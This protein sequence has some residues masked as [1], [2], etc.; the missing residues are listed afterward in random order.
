MKRLALTILLLSG[1]TLR[2]LAASVG[3]TFD[4]E[5]FEIVGKIF[6]N[7]GNVYA[8]TS[9]YNYGPVWFLIL[10]LFQSVASLF[11]NSFLVFR[12]LI[13]LLLTFTDL[14][15]WRLFYNRW[16]L[17]PAF[18]YFLNPISI[19]TTGYYSQFDG[20]AF[21]L[22][23]LSISYLEKSD[24]LHGIRKHTLFG[25]FVMGLSLSTKHFLFF[26]PLWFIFRLKKAGKGILLYSLPYVVFLIS[27]LPF[28]SKGWQGILTNVF[29]YSSLN[30]APFWNVLIPDFL[31]REISPGILFYGAVIVGAWL[32]RKKNLWESFAYYG[33]ILVLFSQAIAEQY[34]IYTLSFISLYFN[35]FFLIFIII[36]TLLMFLMALGGEYTIRPIGFF[37]YRGS[38]GFTWQIVF[39]AL[40]FLY[41][42][43]KKVVKI[44]TS[45]HVIG[46][47]LGVNALFALFINIPSYF[48]DKWVSKIQHAIDE[49]DYEKA[50]DLYG[51]TQA[52]P[53]FAGSRYWWKLTDVRTFIEYFR[54]YR[55]AFSQYESNKIVSNWPETINKLKHIP[56]SFQ[57]RLEVEKIIGETE[58]KSNSSP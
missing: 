10:G 29:Q 11:Q 3:H 31:K 4:M 48:E 24:G 28:I 17:L 41:A 58:N 16:G 43:Y 23:L 36:E 9:R 12:Y 35:P 33:I 30:N 6:V 32:F 19:L 20:L 50:N 40:G 51:K 47:L 57:F 53:P 56:K 54:L 39:L 55:Y 21:F 26:Y 44:I 15:I 8:E 5:S 2:F 34:F 46:F 25:L 7:G 1:I 52:D 14:G 49:G 37:I 22:A 45:K 18:L 27:F 13:L 42:E 38:F